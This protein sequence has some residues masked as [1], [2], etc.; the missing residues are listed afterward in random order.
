M[1]ISFF[2]IVFVLGCFSY[3]VVAVYFFPYLGVRTLLTQLGSLDS[4]E[5]HNAI[6][7]LRGLQYELNDEGHVIMQG[8]VD[9]RFVLTD[10]QK[11]LVEKKI[12][13]ILKDLQDPGEM[14]SIFEI[15][16]SPS[17]HGTTRANLDFG[18]YGESKWNI[19]RN[20]A[21]RFNE[22]GVG[23]DYRYVVHR[24]M[25]VNFLLYT[26]SPDEILKK[27]YEDYYVDP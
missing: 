9:E 26:N 6:M 10:R 8:W 27:L 16:Q 13:S 3:T 24:S 12:L 17:F 14:V 4:L 7:Q 1:R 5:I 19:V 22:F 15:L 23:D 18:K 25:G 21:N 2:G 11:I 20:A